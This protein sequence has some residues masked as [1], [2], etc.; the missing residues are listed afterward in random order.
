MQGYTGLI[1][2][3][4]NVYFLRMKKDVKGYPN[5]ISDVSIR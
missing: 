1:F 2:F 5:V 3:T 4:R